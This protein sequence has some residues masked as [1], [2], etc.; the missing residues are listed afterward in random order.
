M[1]YDFMLNAAADLAKKR[2]ESGFPVNPDDTICILYTNIGNIYTG[3]SS[4]NTNGI[5]HAEIDAVN[6]MRSHGEGIIQA[7]TVLNIRTLSPILPC[8]SCINY[9]IS[10]NPENI[11]CMVVIPNGNI[12]ITEVGMFIA[13]MNQPKPMQTVNSNM[14]FAQSTSYPY[15]AG[16]MPAG[17]IPAQSRAAIPNG[18]NNNSVYSNIQSPTSPQSV[19]NPL[20]SI[21]SQS[22]IDPQPSIN[23]QSV[24]SIYN[25]DANK[26]SGGEYLKNKVND[27]L[28]DDEDDEDNQGKDKK[29]GKRKFGGFF[30]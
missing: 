17:N 4:I 2:V 25:S 5:I 15:M 24:T 9:I 10:I 27:L 18:Y 11:K 19:I 21:N 23:P 14:R 12:R 13:S 3:V 16:S 1:I 29:K 7:I 8:N 30:N 6:S 28:G 22:V 20:P 26:N